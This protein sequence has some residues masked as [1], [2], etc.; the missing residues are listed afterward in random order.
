MV[1]PVAR[2][3]LAVIVELSLAI[4]T[5]RHHSIQFELIGAESLLTR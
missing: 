5:L 1:E 4:T 2:I 3:S